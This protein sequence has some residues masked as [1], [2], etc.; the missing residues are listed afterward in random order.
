MPMMIGIPNQVRASFDMVLFLG[1]CGLLSGLGHKK[2][3]SKPHCS[4]SPAKGH[5]KQH[6]P[7]PHS[8]RGPDA[9]FV[10]KS[11]MLRLAVLREAARTLARRS[12]CRPSHDSS[13][14]EQEPRRLWFQLQVV[15]TANSA[16]PA[17]TSTI[18]R[19]PQAG[20][21]FHK[22]W[23]EKWGLRRRWGI[24]VG[25]MALTARERGMGF[26]DVSG[27]VRGEFGY[28]RWAAGLGLPPIWLCAVGRVLENH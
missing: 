4:R 14:S 10:C 2:G 22:G 18:S 11:K 15:K 19:I 24:R 3:A 16:V 26:G 25:W 17:A 5:T 1:N 23:E 13:W 21:D 28:F 20:S 27:S 6:R 9:A 12:G 7:T 8:G